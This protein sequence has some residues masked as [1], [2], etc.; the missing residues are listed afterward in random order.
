MAAASDSNDASDIFWPGYVDAVTNLAINL[1][2]V[3]AVMSI[4][5]ISTIM[6]I[7][8]M[9][10]D[11]FKPVENAV[12]SKPLSIDQTEKTGNPPLPQTDTSSPVAQAVAPSLDKVLQ[13]KAKAE[14]K[15]REQN[16]QLA[17]L[18]REIDSLKKPLS[19]NAKSQASGGTADLD[20]PAEIVN[21]KENRIK[22]QSG[23]NQLLQVGSGGVIVVFDKDVVALSE[24][25]AAELIEKIKPYLAIE[26]SGFEIRVNTPKGFSE[27]SRIAYYRV[28]DIRNVLIKNNINPGM[29]S[30]RVVESDSP[31]AN[32]ARVLVKPVMP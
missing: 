16:Q 18:Q 17:K 14:E 6:Q 12:T 30:M 28:N 3:I 5:V 2:F 31:S 7:S 23:Q 21:A 10:P 19:V 4:V 9:K 15:L 8:K 11:L 24:K 26:K 25:E 1:L 29:V 27:S 22:T 32:N 20:T 13:D